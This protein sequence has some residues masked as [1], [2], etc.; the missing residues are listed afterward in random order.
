MFNMMTVAKNYLWKLLQMNLEEIVIIPFSYLSSKK[1]I[2]HNDKCYK[3]TLF[4]GNDVQII[5]CPSTSA[6]LP[7]HYNDR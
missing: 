1:P 3:L 6:E 5:Q 4:H 2:K 7:R